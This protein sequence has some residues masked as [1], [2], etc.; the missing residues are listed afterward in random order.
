MGF[1]KPNSMAQNEYRYLAITQATGKE[2]I[3]PDGGKAYNYKLDY[4]Q[5]AQGV[6]VPPNDAA[7]PDWYIGATERVNRMIQGNGAV[8]GQR[9][10]ILKVAD[11]EYRWYKVN[12]DG[13]EQ[14][15][16]DT[17]PQGAPATPP[18][19]AQNAYTPAPAQHPTTPA[20]AAPEYEPHLTM[21]WIVAK[22]THLAVDALCKVNKWAAHKP[23]P[24]NETTI[25]IA[26]TKLS[27]ANM[28]KEIAKNLKI[29]GGGTLGEPPPADPEPV[30][31][32]KQEAFT[33]E[34]PAK[35]PGIPPSPGL[36]AYWDS[37]NLT[38]GMTD[39]SGRIVTGEEGAVPSTDDSDLPF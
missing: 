37:L 32:M 31:D 36:K 13:T 33:S 35:S 20:P 24:E 4:L 19:P 28:T 5:D 39:P 25:F 1:F 6:L 15:L 38:P 16:F 7:Y 14:E 23:T 29:I 18:P 8:A 26:A 17:A 2:K 12:Q 22:T 9:Y 3:F 21:A 30:E 10:R 34:D 11:Q 27:T